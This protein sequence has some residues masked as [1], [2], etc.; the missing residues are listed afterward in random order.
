MKRVIYLLTIPLLLL[1][2]EE[3]FAVTKT[4]VIKNFQFTPSTIT[5]DIGDAIKWDNQD[6]T[7][8][9]TTSTNP[10]GLWGHTLAWG[11]SFTRLFKKEGIYQY[12]CNFHPAMT[13]TITVRTPE[14]TRIKEGKKI[15]DNKTLPITLDLTNKNPNMV[16]LGSYIVNTQSGCANCHSCPTYVPGHNPF[17]GE[18]KQFKA[19]SY[20][21]GGVPINGVISANITPDENNLP[22]GLTLSEF[23]QL[24]RTGQNPDVPGETLQVMPWP[25][26]GM[27]SDHDLEAVYTYL[28]S[29]PLLATPPS[30][31]CSSFGQ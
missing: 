13:G 23:K 15:I 11:E 6:A 18:P 5:I 29:I 25:F 16:Y 26:F 14:Q 1:S 4:I 9:T 28:K 17:K 3:V 27:M 10:A 22:A 24:F 19:G 30:G 21:A 12:H 7:A 31:S 20:L 2:M 8:H